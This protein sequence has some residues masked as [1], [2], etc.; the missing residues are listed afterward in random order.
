MFEGENSVGQ[1]WPARQTAG[2]PATSQT[3][4]LVAKAN[5]PGLFLVSGKGR[6]Q[7]PGTH[8]SN[9]L[10]PETGVY[11]VS[12]SQHR[13]PEEVTLIKGGRFP[14]CSQCEEAVKFKLAAAAPSAGRA[15]DFRVSLYQL[16]EL[17]E[18]A[19]KEKES[20]EEEASAS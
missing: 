17:P 14:V 1:P 9:D 16:P 8:K 6:N 10:V 4:V 20:P 19:P 2:Q 12:H 13:L 15:D 18:E 5:N 3:R 7:S 11:R